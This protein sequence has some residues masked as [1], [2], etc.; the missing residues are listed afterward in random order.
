MNGDPMI[1]EKEWRGEGCIALCKA[2]RHDCERDELGIADCVGQSPRRQ[3]AV[4]VKAG[5]NPIDC[6][7]VAASHARWHRDCSPF[8]GLRRHTAGPDLLCLGLGSRPVPMKTRSA[9][10]NDRP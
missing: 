2:F 10:S 7:T 3:N 9:A 5:A 1:P 4:D 6:M 8:D